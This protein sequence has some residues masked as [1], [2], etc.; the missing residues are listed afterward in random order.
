MTKLKGSELERLQE[1]AR[2]GVANRRAKSLEIDAYVSAL[3]Q[4]INEELAVIADDTSK[5]A[6]LR[7]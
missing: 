3:T 5:G 7:G 6:R 2:S 1:A 4:I